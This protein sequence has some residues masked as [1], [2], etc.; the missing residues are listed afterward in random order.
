MTLLLRDCRFSYGASTVL[1]NVSA[2]FSSGEFISLV[3]PN[4]AGKSTLLH[5]LA[6]LRSDYEGECLLEGREIRQWKRRDLARHIAFVP[7]S[8]SVEFA[9]TSRQ[10]VLMG[11]APFASGFVDSPADHA[12]AEEAM[13]RTGTL[14]F[15]HRDVRLLSG[16]ERQRVLLAAALAQQPRILLLDEPASFLDLEHQLSTYRLLRD[17]SAQGVLCIAATHDLNLSAR[18]SSRSVLVSEGKIAADGPPGEVFTPARL[19]AH[20]QVEASLHPGADGRFWIHY[21]D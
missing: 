6:G 18:Y 17:L 11:R 9:F 1:R 5:L 4:G 10:V 20:F 14:D 16:G 15:A 21:D 3:G 8:L 19:R 2:E 12:A 7:Q 13:R